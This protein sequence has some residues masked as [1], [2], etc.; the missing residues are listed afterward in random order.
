MSQSTLKNAHVSRRSF[1]GG[2]ACAG[3][4]AAL[5]LAGCAPKQQGTSE[6][7][8][9]SVDGS[10]ETTSA[11]SFLT[12]PAP[13]PE[14]EIS[15]TKDAD[16]VIVGCGI[17]GMAAARAATD[18]GAK[19]IVVEKSERFNC[20][21]SMGSQIGSIGSKYQVEAGYPEI[22]ATALINRYMQDT[23]QMANQ[24]LLKHWADHSGQDVE[25]FLELCDEVKLLGPGEMAPEGPLNGT[26]YLM[27]K[28]TENVDGRYPAWATAMSVNFD[29][30]FPED[31]GFYYPM[32]SFQNEVESKGG[33]FMYAT[34]GRQLVKENDRVTAVIV[35]DLE[36]NYTRINAAK[37]VVLSCG[38]F[39]NNKEM[40]E[41]YAPQAVDLNCTY[42][43]M[44]AAGE[45]CNIGEGHQM[46]MWAGAVMEKAPYAPMSHLSDIAD[47]LLVNNRGDRFINEDLGAQSLSNVIMRCPGEIAYCITGEA[48]GPKVLQPGPDAVKPEPLESIEEAAAIV[49][50]DAATLTDTIARYNELAA[51]HF[52]ADFGKT[53]SALVAIEPPYYVYEG[54]PGN[55]LVMMGGIDCDRECRALDENGNPVPGLYV[56]GNNQGCRFGAEYPMT[57][58]GISHGIAL[59]LGRL[60]GTNA[61]TLG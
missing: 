30:T 14:A 13:I 45:I 54:H 48:Q 37:A 7:V 35:Q 51:Q 1:L 41:V 3:A 25:W 20:R 23:L 18:A 40:L 5:G 6:A 22:D 33:E 8:P 24:S 60:A 9:G 57:A 26:V 39:G 42:N 31:A 44:D 36:G 17:A 10:S 12:A 50:C 29:P 21:G 59:S 19:V 15:N 55:M 11:T 43:C 53:P 46:A 28:A 49:G 58:P 32:L 47:V 27:P 52:D 61:Y 16:V 56:A 2:A 38:D 34:W 4:L